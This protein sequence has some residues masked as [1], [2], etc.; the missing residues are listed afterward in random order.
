MAM[1]EAHAAATAIPVIV[2]LLSAIAYKLQDLLA[3]IVHENGD[4]AKHRQAP[5][6]EIE[7]SLRGAPNVTRF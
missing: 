7:L 4:G 3:S 1:I 5:T 2:S 6:N